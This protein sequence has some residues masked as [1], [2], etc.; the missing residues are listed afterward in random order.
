M[1]EYPYYDG[2]NEGYNVITNAWTPLAFD[3]N[4]RNQSCTGAIGRKLYIAGGSN[5][6]GA[7]SVTE[8]F[9]LSTD[10]WTTPLAPMPQATQYPASAVYQG[11][12]YCFGGGQTYP[13]GPVYNVV[14]IYQP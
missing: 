11:R 14:Q 5:I 9:E 8:S 7:L 10:T 13:Q 3:P 1:L 12:L 4:P 2:D 6:G